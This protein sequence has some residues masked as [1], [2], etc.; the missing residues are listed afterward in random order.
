M[1][2]LFAIGIMLVVGGG[3]LL[4]I[5]ILFYMGQRRDLY[6]REGRVWVGMGR[7]GGAMVTAG[8][9]TLMMAALNLLSIASL[10]LIF[11]VLWWLLAPLAMQALP[12]SW[13]RVFEQEHTPRDLNAIRQHG[14]GMLVAEPARFRM[15]IRNLDGWEAWLMSVQSDMPKIILDAYIR[16]AEIAMQHNLLP[17]AHEAADYIIKYR[18]DSDQGYALRAQIHLKNFKFAAAAADYAA[19]ARLAP[20]RADYFLG[21]ARAQLKLYQFEDALAALNHAKQLA[22]EDET[23]ANLHRLVA[24]NLPDLQKSVTLGEISES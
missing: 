5:I 10:T 1:I 16:R 2:V 19:S 18:P 14:V 24:Q 3:W 13:L 21:L 17:L 23:I 8:V 4:R 6:F 20:H 12:P 7:V 22:P 9:G 11:T 15:V